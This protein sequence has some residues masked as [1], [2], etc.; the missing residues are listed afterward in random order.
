MSPNSFASIA[1]VCPQTP[2][3]NLQLEYMDLWIYGHQTRTSFY[4]VG[5]FLYRLAMFAAVG[6]LSWQMVYF[7][8][9]ASIL[10]TVLHPMVFEFMA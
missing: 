6:L 1:F 10:V 4:M 2:I 8:I 3:L 5:M 9:D 7:E